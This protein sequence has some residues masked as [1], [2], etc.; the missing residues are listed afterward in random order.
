MMHTSQLTYF[1]VAMM[2]YCE[3]SSQNS[4]CKIKSLTLCMQMNAIKVD[5]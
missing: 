5:Y 1:C 3:A 2:I 4:S